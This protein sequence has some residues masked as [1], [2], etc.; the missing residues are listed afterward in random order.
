MESIQLKV[1]NA[2]P[3]STLRV[4]F[5][6]GCSIYLY[7]RKELFSRDLPNIEIGVCGKGPET[8]VSHRTLIWAV[9]CN[10]ND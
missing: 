1:S 9:G 7:Y 5:A 3:V 2:V 8:V 10:V 6:I 4:A